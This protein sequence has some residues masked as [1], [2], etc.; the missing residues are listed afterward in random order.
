M[1]EFVNELLKLYEQ[2]QFSSVYE[3][4]QVLTKQYAGSFLLWN[5]L[6]VSAGQIRKFEKA[7]DAFMKSISL[8]PDYAEAYSNL[9]NVLK[10]QGKLN[11]A[12]EAYK[13]SIT[14]KPEYAEAYFNI[15]IALKDIGNIDEAIKSFS[16]INKL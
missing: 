10:D 11:E 7:T 6:G 16:S 9:G 2:R 14:F 3:K 12:I 1:I 13:K 8:K 15:G 5:I 4:A